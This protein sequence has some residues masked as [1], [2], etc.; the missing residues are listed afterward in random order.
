[1]GY[2]VSFPGKLDLNSATKNHF[3]NKIVGIIA[4]NY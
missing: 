3:G 1:M 2:V 4:K